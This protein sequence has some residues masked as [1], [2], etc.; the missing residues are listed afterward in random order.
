MQQQSAFVFLFLFFKCTLLKVHCKLSK[1]PFVTNYPCMSLSFC[2]KELFLCCY[3]ILPLDRIEIAILLCNF[4][5]HL[6]SVYKKRKNLVASTA[7]SVGII[8]QV[9]QTIKR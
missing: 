7:I 5:G 9:K 3:L 8:F 6:V 1:E 4:K 2:Y